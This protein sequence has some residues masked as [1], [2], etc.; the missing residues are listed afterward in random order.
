MLYLILSRQSLSTF[1]GESFAWRPSPP[2]AWPRRALPHAHTAPHSA[3]HLPRVQMAPK[4]AVA[5]KSPAKK[6][7]VKKTIAKKA[8]AKKAPVKKTTVR[9]RTL[10]P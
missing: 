10:A 8:P 7:P 3:A 6:A 9:L 2:L 1:E 4:K 5:K